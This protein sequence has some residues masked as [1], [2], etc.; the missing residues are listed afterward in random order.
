MLA[1]VSRP[2]GNATYQE[3]ATRSI[4]S[5]YR[6]MNERRNAI[7]AS[8]EKNRLVEGVGNHSNGTAAEGNPERRPRSPACERGSSDKEGSSRF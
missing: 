6:L 3:E 5:I 8:E 4:T 1:L 2:T 7:V